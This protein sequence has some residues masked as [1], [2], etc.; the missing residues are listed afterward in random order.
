MESAPAS[1]L[2]PEQT[3]GNA[4]SAAQAP[5]AGEAAAPKVKTPASPAEDPAF[6]AVVGGIKGVAAQEQ[7]H[8]PAAAKA[9]EAQA[10]AQSPPAELAGQA[11][12]GQVA[13]MAAAPTPG[14]D[15]AAF[16]RK[17]LERIAA[18]A[19][20]TAED[21]D[22][23]KENNKLD[24][25]KGSLRE[26]AGQQ[27]QTAQAPLAQA[28]AAAPDT[29]GVEPKPVTPLPAAQPG[30]TPRLDA[31]GNAAPKPKSAAEVEAPLQTAGQPLEQEM[32]AA[33]VSEE[34]LAKA[35]EPSF[36]AALTAK[37]QAETHSQ[38]APAQIRAAEQ[39]ELGQA[40]TDAT[41]LAAEQRR[42]ARRPHGGIGPGAGPAGRS[43][44][45]R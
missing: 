8:A 11:A 12:T 22:K 34:Q 42:H 4:P 30:P 13:E 41:A 35:N 43:Q 9:A 23:F 45:P 29:S 36:S 32:A 3:A 24:G 6:Q 44:G 7:A 2:S 17:L 38:S 20:Q 39:S 25:V 1:P 14:F 33:E 26:E 27:R 5:S 31:A 10:A 19:P 15:A 16:K 40:Q 28:T 21:A 37:T 18:A